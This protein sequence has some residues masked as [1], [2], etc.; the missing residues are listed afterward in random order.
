MP[1]SH[2]LALYIARY[3]EDIMAKPKLYQLKAKQQHGRTKLLTVRVDEIHCKILDEM[4][5][6]DPDRITP[7]MLIRRAIRQ[8]L[9]REG[10][11]EVKS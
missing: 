7:S 5:F 9:E 1:V 3:T 2:C 11:L 4:A 8:Y 10:K 6:A